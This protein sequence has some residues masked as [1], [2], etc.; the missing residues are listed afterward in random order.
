MTDIQN[1]DIQK[2]NK[3]ISVD[4][5]AI[6]IQNTRMINNKYFIIVGKNVITSLDYENHNSIN[7]ILEK[8]TVIVDQCYNNNILLF[9]TED[10]ELYYFNI[11]PIT[12]YKKTI[13]SINSKY[14]IKINPLIFPI[15][16]DIKSMITNNSN[17]ALTIYYNDIV[18]VIGDYVFIFDTNLFTL[19]DISYNK[20]YEAKQI[21]FNPEE[22]Y[23]L[24]NY[25]HDGFLNMF[26]VSK[27][28]NNITYQCKQFKIFY[29]KDNKDNKDKKYTRFPF[30]I[31]TICNKLI[32]IDSENKIKITNLEQYINIDTCNIDS[33]NVDNL[34]E[35]INI[36]YEDPNKEFPIS[37]NIHDGLIYV[38]TY[39]NIYYC[40]VE[41]YNSTPSKWIKM[42]V[43]DVK[44]I[45][46]TIGDKYEPNFLY[47]LKQ[48]KQID[49]ID[50][51]N[52]NDDNDDMYEIYD[53]NIP[54]MWSRIKSWPY[55]KNSLL[56]ISFDCNIH[57]IVFNEKTKLMCIVRTYIG[58]YIGS[59]INNIDNVR[60]N[61]SKFTINNKYI[62]DVKP[63]QI[64]TN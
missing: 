51:S 28:N 32:I 52:D 57:K 64:L 24:L 29:N 34:W 14:T 42:D 25:L 44:D 62:I 50:S 21:T 31:N 12:T 36:P 16:I 20:D 7:I 63:T 37:T 23:L 9:L 27:V 13:K 61:L 54:I 26:N 46:Q 60:E 6:V 10:F 47:T 3:R 48:K 15:D 11:Y 4:N 1:T 8:T 40:N 33:C 22:Q 17:F 30:D 45:M 49:I 19:T 43:Y 58:A 55:N 39:K 38:A 41:D 18:I 5:F 35:Y 59:Y 53:D 2:A 56:A